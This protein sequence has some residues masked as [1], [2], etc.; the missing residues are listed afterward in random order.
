M[1]LRSLLLLL[2]GILLAGGA[3]ILHVIYLDQTITIELAGFK[4]TPPLSLAILSLVIL[5]IVLVLCWKLVS[6]ILFFPYHLKRW[7][8][9]MR[10]KRRVKVIGEGLQSMVLGVTL[11]QY[12]SFKAAGDA[13]VAPASSYYLAAAASTDEKTQASLLRKAAKSEGEP[14]VQAM[15]TA[16]MRLKENLPAEACEVLRT[17]GAATNKANQPLRLLLE[18]L[19]R[20]GDNRGALDVAQTL[21]ARDPSPALSR[22]VHQ[23][24][25]ELLKDAGNPDDVHGLLGS[26]AKLNGS[27]AFALAA[28]KQLVAVNDVEGAT[29]L[30]L[31][32]WKQSR[33][34]ETL[35]AIAKHGNSE[36]VKKVLAQTDDVL[37][38]D[39]G[40]PDLMCAFAELAMRE[41]LYGQARKLLND[42][43][44]IKAKRSIYLSFARLADAEGKSSEESNRLYKLAAQTSE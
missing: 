11:N 6:L 30:L 28:A 31:Q 34:P 41:K 20:T 18:A 36:A 38:A 35:E 39:P 5:A 22:R 12:K 4:A 27:S 29:S 43:L 37:A 33:E 3:W 16:R 15:A 13:G 8:S 23:I 17:A 26:F 44:K 25:S 10:E 42:A 19:E 14:M 24:T 40:N 1:R 32:A 21:L 9:N 7:H 2:I